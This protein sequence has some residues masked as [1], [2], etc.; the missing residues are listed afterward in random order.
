MPVNVTKDKTK[1]TGM[2]NTEGSC[3]IIAMARK[4]T[5]NVQR[6][7]TFVLLNHGTVNRKSN[8]TTPTI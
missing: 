3:G 8:V 6:S 2:P 5:P 4:L 7:I 1:S